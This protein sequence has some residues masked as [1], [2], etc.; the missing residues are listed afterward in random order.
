MELDLTTNYV[1]NL[2]KIIICS[3]HKIEHDNDKYALVL[4]GFCLLTLY[5]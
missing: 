3:L 4:V 2:S 1:G 5:V